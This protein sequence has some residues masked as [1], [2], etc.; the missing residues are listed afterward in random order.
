MTTDRDP[1]Q[2]RLLLLTLARVG[3]LVLA[4]IGLLL[5]QTTLFGVPHPLSGRVLIAV[6]LFEMLVVPP[7]LLRRW[8]AP[9]P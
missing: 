7:L 3:G 8:R 5:W 9:K 1:A 4:G 2:N 6:G